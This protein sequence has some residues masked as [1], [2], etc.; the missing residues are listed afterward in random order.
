MGIPA[1][2]AGF[3]AHTLGGSLGGS[4]RWGAYSGGVPALGGV[5]SGGVWRLPVTA[6][7]A[8]G[9]H[10]TGMHSCLPVYFNSNPLLTFSTYV[11]L[12]TP[13]SQNTPG[14]DF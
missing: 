10:P 9:T 11:V 5:C 13:R 2:L 3:H 1:S 6:T 12:F 8:D 7:A 14:A 4:S